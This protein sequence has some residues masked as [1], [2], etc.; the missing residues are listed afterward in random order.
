MSSS[1]VR[2]LGQW[3]TARRQLE[4]ALL[5]PRII[6]V[7][8]WSKIPETDMEPSKNLVPSVGI[9]VVPS[10]YGRSS[11]TSWRAGALAVAGKVPKEFGQMVMIWWLPMDTPT[12]RYQSH[13]F[14]IMRRS[15]ATRH[16]PEYELLE[17]VS[18]S[19]FWWDLERSGLEV[20]LL[21][22]GNWSQKPWEF[23]GGL[24][25]DGSM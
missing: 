22:W 24:N 19:M 23:Q 8:S 4:G 21:R 3:P 13:Y 18:D 11:W 6:W 15:W 14:P 2:Q 25:L 1:E 10:A 9:L 20:C 17:Y 12:R 16:A 7:I 5:V